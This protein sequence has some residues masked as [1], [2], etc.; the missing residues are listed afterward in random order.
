[1]LTVEIREPI[2][3]EKLKTGIAGFDFV[4]DG[5][6]PKSRVTLV[7]GSAGSAKTVLA[8]QFL[9]EGIRQADEGGVFVTLEE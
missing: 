7:S 3:I 1:L 5:G 2:H 4:S 6:L 8:V 9:A